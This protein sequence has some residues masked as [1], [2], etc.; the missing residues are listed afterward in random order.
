MLLSNHFQDFL[1]DKGVEHQRTVPYCSAQ[2]GI[3]E[4]SHYTLRDMVRSMLVHSRL[5]KQYWGAALLYATEICNVMPHPD[6]KQETTPHEI[7]FGK[8]PNMSKFKVFGC[9]AYAVSKGKYRNKLEPRSKRYIF[10]G[11]AENQK[12]WKL[13]DP[14]TLTV[15]VHRDVIFHEDM[16]THSN[17]DT[18]V[19]NFRP[20][21]FL[22]DTPIEGGCQISMEDINEVADDSPSE[23]NVHEMEDSPSE[24]IESENGAE[25]NQSSTGHNNVDFQDESESEENLCPQIEQTIPIRRS[26]RRRE[27]PRAYWMV[28]PDEAS[29]EISRAA[30]LENVKARDIQIPKT[31]REAL[32]SDYKREWLEAMHQEFRS[33]IKNGSWRNETPPD[34][35]QAIDS[36]WIFTVKPKPDGSIDRFKARLVIRG[37]T[38]RYGVD[39]LETFAPVAKTTSIRTILALA[40]KH[41]Y[42]LRHVDFETVYL[43]GDLDEEIWMKLPQDSHFLFS[44]AGDEN[45]HQS[46]VRLLKGLYGLKQA[47]RVWN[48]QIN[49]FLISIGFTRAKADPCIYTK[50][51]G[52]RIFILGLY[53]DDCLIAYS[54]DSDLTDVLK[55]LKARYNIKD[56]GQPQQILGMQVSQ[57]PGNEIK[58]FQ[59]QYIKDLLKRFR[60]ENCNPAATPH[61]PGFK[62]SGDMGEP[63]DKGIPYAELIGSL[64]WASVT[65]RPDISYIVSKLCR[66]V[67]KPTD[68]LWKAAK[69]VLRYLK[70]T[71]TLG[72]QYHQ[73]PDEESLQGYTDSDWAG[74]LD[75]RKST[76]G[77]CYILSG[78]L[79]SWRSKLQQSI[80]LS[81]SE[82]EYMAACFA[83]REAVW[84]RRLLEELTGTAL[85]QPTVLKA[86]NNGCISLSE[87]WRADQRTKHIEVQYHFLREQV[88]AKVV[89]LVKESTHDIVADSLTK[90]VPKPKFLWCRD[91]F[92]L[93]E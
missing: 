85:D 26:N 42:K 21:D 91:Q 59:E 24:N 35:N 34:E 82:A 11:L 32:D 75:N 56:L 80:A 36:K 84:I 63:L 10:V 8:K 78:S 16:F 33:L 79:I 92:G 51:E 3:V 60:I 64:N 66:H 48:R 41:N 58:I 17:S 25:S 31:V 90:P 15:S 44:D 29:E 69:H 70:G 67:S 88:E 46:T 65:T 49:D 76:S 62:Y 12:G 6:A 73:S 18:G 1:R 7:V 57:G 43:N 87:N 30:R 2:N 20:E 38:Q 68:L 86:D 5:S 23:N 81:A 50:H 47:G 19:Y 37:F 9:D 74:D 77:F 53:V 39:Y 28:Q 71:A 22:T 27:A 55:S 83:T 72:L 93:V 14:E 40:A 13:Q 45:I 4:R 52:G 61:L 54:H 89:S